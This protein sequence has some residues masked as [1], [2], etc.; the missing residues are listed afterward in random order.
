MYKLLIGF[1]LIL[2][3]LSV[4][5]QGVAD[6]EK[7]TRGAKYLIITFDRYYQ[8]I[9]KF[10]HWKHKKGIS[11]KIVKIS[12]IGGNKPQLIKDY[13]SD[14][15]YSWE[16]VPE[17]VLLVGDI[18][19][20]A[21]Y[22]HPNVGASDN[23]YADVNNDTLLE[24]SIGRLPAHNKQQL[25]S[26][27]NKIFNYERKPYLAETTFYKTALTIRQDPGPFHNAGVRFVRTMILDNSD[28]TQVDTLFNPAHNKYDV[29]D[30]IKAGR[31]YVFYTGHGAGTHWPSPFNVTPYINNKMK[32]PV[33]FSWS[34]QTVLKKNYLGQKW[35]KSGSPRYP[36]GAVAYI[37]TT[38]SGLYARYRN[39]VARNFFRSVFQ[40]K[41][42]NIGNALKEGL[43]SLWNYTPD[44]FGRVLY[45]EFNLLGDPTMCLW[46][47]IPKPMSVEH[48]TIISTG[49]QQFNVYVTNPEGQEIE[50]ALV[51][52]SVPDD[53]NF[54]YQGHTN[55]FGLVSFQI[56]ANRY[57]SILITV[58][59]QNYIPY[60]G[61]CR[62]IPKSANIVLSGYSQRDEPFSVYPNPAKSEIRIRCPLSANKIKIFDV[63]G[64]VAKDIGDCRGD[65]QRQ[66]HNDGMVRISLDGVKNG[67]YFVSV[68]TDSNSFIERFVIL[69]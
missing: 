16:I 68:E 4:R 59:A 35:L 51:C 26:M 69:K 49:Q 63:T 65:Y 15:Y 9:Q 13:I 58:T 2:T 25:R 29:Q 33:I 43:D 36:R 46:T 27:I 32:T 45:S 20:I 37:G 42:L 39:F 60:E 14:A 47:S 54:Y 3:L 7:C 34:C 62:V 22:P 55:I 12:E 1:T 44:F 50:H 23:P 6:D 41:A 67:V 52:L 18:N 38:T 17:Y 40:N 10:A 21:P 56:E 64:K 24:M 8:I 61:K 53:N 57:D 31:G 30:S 5:A 28:F 66:P 11:T 19:N 48:D